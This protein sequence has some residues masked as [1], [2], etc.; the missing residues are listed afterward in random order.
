MSGHIYL[1]YTGYI[2]GVLWYLSHNWHRC[3]TGCT[4]IPSLW[5]RLS[6]WC[7]WHCAT[8]FA[9]PAHGL[10]LKG[11]VVVEMVLVVVVVVVAAGLSTSLSVLS[12]SGLTAE[13]QQQRLWRT[14][15]TPSN[16]CKQEVT[17]ACL[18]YLT[19]AANLQTSNIPTH[20]LTHA[21]CFCHYVLL[22]SRKSSMNK[23]TLIW[24]CKG[25]MFL[26]PF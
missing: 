14:C 9:L 3:L 5:S 13:Q 11:L 4:T 12:S 10:S 26:T 23:F 25:G 16:Y 1:P 2:P 24:D 21:E 20:H 19:Y 7:N 8:V 22:W 15:S 17:L 6:K 18:M